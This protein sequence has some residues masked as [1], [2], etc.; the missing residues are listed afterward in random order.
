MESYT[1][2]PPKRPGFYFQLSAIVI[3]IAAGIYGLYRMFQASIGPAFVVALIPVLFAAS[4]TPPLIYRLISL[5]NASYG[6]Q[7]DGIHLQWGQRLEDIPMNTVLWVRPASDLKERLPLPWFFWPGSVL[8][9]RRH[10]AAGVVEYM[11]S[12][13]HSLI[14]IATPGHIYAIS[15]ADRQAFLAS[16][17]RL[18]ELG[19]LT[20][21]T[22]RSIRPSLWIGRVW[23]DQPA[24]W[25]ILAGALLSLALLT[26]ASLM[27][28]Q[29]SEISLGFRPDGSLRKP[30]PS[31]QLMLLPVLNGLIFLVNL[32][33]GLA[34]FRQEGKKN[35][36]YLLWGN[37]V[38]IAS[39][40]LLGLFLIF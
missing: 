7:R 28:P 5:V 40:F 19:S 31:V 10:P 23:S 32:L 27:I 13:T 2:L 8:G 37:M 35:L 16:Y 17:N 1:F 9:I 21:I 29:L 3:L 4:L 18:A 20:P 26:W 22:A 34:L 14:L 12:T 30:V 11:A 38:V 15:P 33:V 39:L 25:L 24:R 6:L 36:A